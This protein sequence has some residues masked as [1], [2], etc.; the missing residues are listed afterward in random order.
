M[1]Y[2]IAI[3]LATL[4]AICAGQ[5]A[6][7][8]DLPDCAKPCAATLPANC[9]LNVQ[10]ICTDKEWITNISCCVKGKCSE[11][12]QQKTI[13]VAQQICDT[14]KVTLPSAA[15]CP[16]DAAS[17]GSSTGGSS[18]KAGS[19]TMTGSAMMGSSTKSGT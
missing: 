16:G 19:S 10:C 6:G 1:Q 4:A 7:L 2:T 13:Q 5:G 15:T 14:V 11:S 9:G 12:E 3:W 17:T 8:G 18:T